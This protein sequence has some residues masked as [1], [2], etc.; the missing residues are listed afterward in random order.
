MMPSPATEFVLGVIAWVS[1]IGI[2][3]LCVVMWIRYKE[4]RRRW[5]HDLCP[6]CG[7]DL[8]AS[9]GRCPECG[10]RIRKNL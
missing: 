2:P 8:R 3:V 1:G 5:D 6:I 7:Y 10:E 9:E 4:R